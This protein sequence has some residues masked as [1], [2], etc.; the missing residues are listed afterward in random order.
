VL[1]FGYIVNYFMQHQQTYLLRHYSTIQLWLRLM[2]KGKT[3][4]VSVMEIN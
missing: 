3:N 4:M 2:K 1:V